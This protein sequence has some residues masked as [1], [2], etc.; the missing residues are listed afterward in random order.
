M[1][2]RCNLT[3]SLRNNLL[4]LL[5]QANSP[6]LTTLE[7]PTRRASKA[8][9]IPDRLVTI[10]IE[11]QILVTFNHPPSSLLFKWATVT[12]CGLRLILHR[13][14]RVTLLTT[15]I[16]QHRHLRVGKFVGKAIQNFNHPMASLTV[17]RMRTDNSPVRFRAL[18]KPRT[19]TMETSQM[20]TS[21]ATINLVGKKIANRS[22]LNG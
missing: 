12:D 18:C 13:H 17:L 8:T 20:A 3:D 16:K 19:I 14:K 2:R 6:I 5:N 10:P 9:R 22:E 15:G 21:Q 11:T 7:K 4:E 1:R